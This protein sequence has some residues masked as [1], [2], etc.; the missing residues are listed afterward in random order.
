MENQAIKVML[1]S[2]H[3]TL[4]VIEGFKEKSV[5]SPLLVKID[6]ALISLIFI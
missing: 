3:N 4:F 6:L 2:N 1:M 5:E